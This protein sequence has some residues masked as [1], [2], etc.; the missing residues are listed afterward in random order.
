MTQQQKAFLHHLLP[1]HFQDLA[2]VFSFGL[3]PFASGLFNSPL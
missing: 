2:R 3:L 1:N